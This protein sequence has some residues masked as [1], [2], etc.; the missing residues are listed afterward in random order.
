MVI[1]HSYVS[2]PEGTL[3][4]SL[5]PLSVWPTLR[6]SNMEIGKSL[7]DP[8]NWTNWKIISQWWIFQQAMH[9][10]QEYPLVNIQKTTVWKSTIFNGK[11]HYKWPFS[12][13]MVN[14]QE[15]IPTCPAIHRP[16]NPLYVKLQLRL[17]PPPVALQHQPPERMLSS[18]LWFNQQTLQGWNPIYNHGQKLTFKHTSHMWFDH[19]EMYLQYS[20]PEQKK[21][22]QRYPIDNIFQLSYPF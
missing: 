2:L 14:Y 22:I 16:S 19:D 3:S 18:E 1:F 15:Y 20:K 5:S 11:T 8:W 21:N 17:P 4:S 12:M 13:A 9:D 6:E 10:D 7:N